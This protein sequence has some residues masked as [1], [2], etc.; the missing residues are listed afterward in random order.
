MLIVERLEQIKKT[1]EYDGFVHLDVK[2]LIEQ[3]EQNTKLRQALNDIK[4][5]DERDYQDDIVMIFDIA[6]KALEE[7]K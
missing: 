2:W 7:T 1:W 3:A 6:D 5:V 4:K